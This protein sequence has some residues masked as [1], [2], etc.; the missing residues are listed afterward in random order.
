MASRTAKSLAEA[1]QAGR[2]DPVDLAVEVFE[3]IR[4][5]GDPAIFIEELPDRAMAE[6]RASRER[7][8][9][10]LPASLLDGVPIAW[11]DLF[12]LKGRVTTA[13]SVVLK[14]EAPAAA[15]APVVAAGHRAGMVTTGTLNMTEF[16]YSGIGLNPHYGTPLNPHAGQGPARSPGGSSSGAGVVVARD[17]VSVAMGTDTGGSVRIP[18]SFNGVVGYKT[19]TGHY[20][21]QGVFPLARTLDSLGPLAHTVEDCV[22]FDAVLRGLA[23][24]E[25]DASKVEQLTFL[26]PDDVMFDNAEPA[27][28]ENFNATVARL[29]AEG[30]RVRR[31]AMPQLHQIH[32]LM[33]RHGFLA[34]AE[35]LAVHQKRLAGP[36][37][38]QMDARVVRRIRQAET[39]S[40]VDLVILQE[41][42][43]RLIAETTAIIGD[44]IL[45]CP[46]TATV[47]M[48]TA[49][50]EADQDVFFA[51]N[52][53]TLRNTSLGNFL[54]WCGVSIPNGTDADGLPTGFLMSGSHG[55][56]HKLLCAALGSEEVIRG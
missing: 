26:I 29:E 41:A 17:I 21:M 31:V 53:L 42:R 51:H 7:L 19:S 5:V 35:A 6:A 36:D 13:G 11:K 20:P 28:V 27:V 3:K 55:Q 30:A 50:L 25:A 9:A 4:Q 33:Q 14:R 24:P 34:G 52:G 45:I 38:A 49:P 46:T 54:D 22:L 23:Q 48:Q 16:A 8:K 47:A 1:L 37:A 18:A 40:A 12:D 44:A 32:E 15:D 56:D 10:G 2:I 43:T 39:M